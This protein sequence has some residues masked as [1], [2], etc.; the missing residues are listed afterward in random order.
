MDGIDFYVIGQYVVIGVVG[1]GNGVV[2]VYYVV[3]IFFVVVEVVI[4]QYEEVWIVDG[5][6]WV[7]F[8]QFQ[9]SQ[10]YEGFVG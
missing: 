1:D 4:V 2:Y 6:L 5:I 9:C 8:V 7:V 3:V 10:C